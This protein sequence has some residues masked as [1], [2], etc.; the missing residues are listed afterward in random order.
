MLTWSE[1]STRVKLSTRRPGSQCSVVTQEP[2]GRGN[3]EGGS[4]A[5]VRS[6]ELCCP[7]PRIPEVL[8]PP[9]TPSWIPQPTKR[10]RTEH[11]Q[12]VLASQRPISAQAG[13][14]FILSLSLWFPAHCFHGDRT[15]SERLESSPQTPWCSQAHLLPWLPRVWKYL[16]SW[17]SGAKWHRGLLAT[18]H[19]V[20]RS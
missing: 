20:V 2:A 18:I 7:Q 13:P 17:I 5:S 3:R 4:E 14:T 10:R 19:R 1:Q 16:R 12:V 11:S 6:L 15:P 8:W 9:P